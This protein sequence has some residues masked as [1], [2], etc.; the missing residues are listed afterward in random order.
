MPRMADRRHDPETDPTVTRARADLRRI[1]AEGD[2]LGDSAVARAGKSAPMPVPVGPEDPPDAV[3]IW[4]KRVARG[5]ALVFL[6]WS[7]WTLHGL[8]V[9]P[10]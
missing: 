10:G 5:L 6:A 9:A 4:A 1:A 7:V 3:E 2:G 8:L